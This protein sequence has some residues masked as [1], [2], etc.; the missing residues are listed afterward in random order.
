MTCEVQIF[1]GP[2]TTQKK[3]NFPSFIGTSLQRST[4]NS[5]TASGPGLILTQLGCFQQIACSTLAHIGPLLHS[6]KLTVLSLVT[7]RVSSQRFHVAA[8]VGELHH[9][10]VVMRELAGHVD[11]LILDDGALSR[12]ERQDGSESEDDGNTHIGAGLT[13]VDSRSIG[14]TLQG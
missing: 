1:F 8:A 6:E 12:T 3:I 5:V 10:R 13:G 7:M 14:W 9:A 11:F 4:H 2:W